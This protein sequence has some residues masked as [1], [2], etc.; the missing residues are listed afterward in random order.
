MITNGES[1]KSDVDRR[2]GK[3]EIVLY[4]KLCGGGLI[5]QAFIKR[6][7]YLMAR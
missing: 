4:S 2:A 5:R 3:Q 6:W 7:D 1:C